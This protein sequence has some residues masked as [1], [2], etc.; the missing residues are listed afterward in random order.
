MSGYIKL[1]RKIRGNPLFKN[2][3]EARHLFLDILTFVAY[4]DTV[5]DWR[6][7]PVDLQPGQ[8]MLSSR[9][10]AEYTGFGRQKIRALLNSL[11]SHLILKINPLPNQ[12]PMIISVCNWDAYQSQKPTANP[13]ANPLPT[14]CQPT[15]EEREEVKERKKN[16]SFE[17]E[18]AFAAFWSAYP[19]KSGKAEALKKFTAIVNS[20]QATA[21]QLI[22]AAKARVGITSTDQ[23][24]IPLPAT[25]LNKQRWSDVENKPSADV[26]TTK[27]TEWY[28]YEADNDSDSDDARNGDYA[29]G[30]CGR[31]AL[32][33]VPELFEPEET[34]EPQ[35]TSVGRVDRSQGVASVLH[36]LRLEG[37]AVR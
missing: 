10:L 30:L 29:E 20:G 18:Q 33:D 12:G 16:I 23:K 5:Q 9:E 31:E 32:D 1:H 8:A 25:W 28:R 19:R 24:F 13:P 11:T 37:G 7:S 27:L 21:E 35:K 3:P 17:N 14:H 2:K 15:K 26:S 34:S 4:A 36:P 6:G 22:A